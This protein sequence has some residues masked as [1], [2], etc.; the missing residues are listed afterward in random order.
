ML[1]RE[2]VFE[3]RVSHPQEV[4]AVQSWQ[5]LA[6]LQRVVGAG[7]NTAMTPAAADSSAQS[8]SGG[9]AAA[10]L[11]ATAQGTSGGCAML[12]LKQLAQQASASGSARQ[13]VNRGR[14]LVK[15]DETVSVA[16][17][18]TLQDSTCCSSSLGAVEQLQHHH[19]LYQQHTVLVE[20]TPVWLD[21]PASILE[22][23]VQPQAAVVD[24]SLR[25]HCPEQ[26]LLHVELGL[27]DLPGVSAAVLAAA[28]RGQLAVVA[29]RPDVSVKVMATQQQS[30]MVVDAASAY[31]QP[32]GYQDQQQQMQS[33]CLRHRCGAAHEGTVQFYV[34]LY[35]D[36]AMA[37]PLETWQVR[38]CGIL[39][40][41]AGPAHE[42]D[43][44]AR[45]LSVFA[46]Q[47]L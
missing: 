40:Q 13:L 4:S 47:P 45:Q 14:I 43:G 42:T 22:L 2:A 26:E 5:E 20:F 38:S 10:V 23:D 7:I 16:L 12:G 31:R 8:A 41:T 27:T 37:Q 18:F 21:W 46:C 19:Q 30:R 24:R 33:L 25:Y 35:G 9:A 1:G 36:A 32:S 44:I 15:A 11:G 6:D 17:R 34:W 28:A 29:S 39:W 3:L